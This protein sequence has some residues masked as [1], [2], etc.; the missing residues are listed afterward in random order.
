MSFYEMSPMGGYSMGGY[1]MGGV[2]PLTMA[3]R[4]QREA[5][6]AET[7]ARIAQAL[8]SGQARTLAEAKQIAK[9]LRPK[10]ARPKKGQE[11]YRPPVKG[12][13]ATM[14]S[15]ILKRIQQPLMRKGEFVM[16]PYQGDF[17][18]QYL[19]NYE[20][21]KEGRARNKA[22]EMEFL[23]KLSAFLQQEGRGYGMGG[24]FL[25]DLGKIATIAT[26]FLL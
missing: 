22:N 18:E 23:Q 5:T 7:D 15:S 2:G 16:P 17:G 14:K 6:K 21:G 8:I 26:P 12:E 4:Q 1:P 24:N 9:E 19:T 20:Q 25:D 13:F 11:G 10:I 3:Q